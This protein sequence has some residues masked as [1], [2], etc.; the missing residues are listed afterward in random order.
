MSFV[1]T[2][3][4][5]AVVG[6]TEYKN[7]YGRYHREDGP[8]ITYDLGDR[9]GDEFWFYDGKSHRIKGPADSWYISHP[10]TFCLVS[11]W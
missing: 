8:A 3:N 6:R 2:K 7:Q 11:S 1:V 10:N 4:S 5:Q 9:T